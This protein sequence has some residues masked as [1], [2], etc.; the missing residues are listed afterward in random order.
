MNKPKH[1]IRYVCSL[2]PN[3]VLGFYGPDKKR[4]DTYFNFTRYTPDM[5]RYTGR[6]SVHI[7][8]FNQEF[9]EQL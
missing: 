7:E 3:E 2:W 8:Y 6:A 4:S 9:K 5:K 1:G